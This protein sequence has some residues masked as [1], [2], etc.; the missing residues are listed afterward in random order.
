MAHAAS[1]TK[2][3]KSGK[4]AG[5][6]KSK[7]I[8]HQQCPKRLWLEKNRP[9]LQED[10]QGSLAKME[11]GHRVG[12]LAQ[13][14]FPNGVLI[15]EE[16]LSLA[17]ER[18]R[19]VMEK[20]P[21]KPIYE[22]TFE[23]DGVLIRADILLPERGGAYR[24]IEVKSSTSVK[25]YHHNDIAIQSSVTEAA[26]VKLKRIELAHIDN[27]FVYQGNGDY[28]GL[29]RCVSMADDIAH[30]KPQVPEWVQAARKTLSG[31]EPDIAVG[32]QCSDP[33]DCPFADYCSPQDPEAFPVEILPRI[34]AAQV[35]ALKA[36]GYTDLRDI[37]KGVL[38]NEKHELVRR[39]TRTNQRHLNFSATLAF[40]DDLSWPRYFM[41]F[42]T[43]NPAIPQWAGSRP[44]QQ[45]PF[46]WSCHVQGRNGELRHEEFLATGESDPRRTF[47]ESLI[48]TLKQRGPVLVY[49]AAFEV[50]RLRELATHFPDLNEALQ[51][52]IERVVDLLPVA[53]EHYYHPAMRGSWSIKAVLPTIA[54]EL[55]YDNLEVAD[56]G[57]AQEAFM[58]ILHPDTLPERRQAL[59]QG[60]LQYCE[61]DTLAM[62]RL[63]EFFARGK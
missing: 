60:L 4:R 3:G 62:V 56:G 47:A 31:E 18:T 63:A 43:I 41:D 58:E 22:A 8:S 32:K 42:E 40:M 28:S 27:E 24:L 1:A 19:E 29:L 15:E 35:A 33:F 12:E 49:N 30:L 39:V 11:T 50:S 21:R 53:R 25:P 59:R 2:Q 9:E 5:L 14:L 6:S 57:M 20:H 48:Q 37:P 16:T 10:D 36:K 52:I 7:I 34:S 13:Q 51:R 61:R 45:I 46:Q 55:A 17:V 54:P 26:G 38:N 23:H 44:Y